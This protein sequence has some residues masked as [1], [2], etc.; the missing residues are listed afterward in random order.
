MKTG[1][2]EA[3]WSTQST[4]YN[5]NGTIYYQ[6]SSNGKARLRSLASCYSYTRTSPKQ[7]NPHGFVS[8]KSRM[9]SGKLKAQTYAAYYGETY[10]NGPTSQATDPGQASAARQNAEARASADISQAIAGCT[11]FAVSAVELTQTLRMLGSPMRNI[12]NLATSLVGKGRRPD[13][14]AQASWVDRPVNFDRTVGTIEAS[15][16]L[17]LQFNLGVRPLLSD[18]YAIAGDYLGM[19]DFNPG[20][21]KSL[22]VAQAKGYQEVNDRVIEP[23]VSFIASNPSPYAINNRRYQAFCSIK[24]AFGVDPVKMYQMK[25]RYL[26]LSPSSVAWE[27]VPASYIVDY[28]YD[29]GSYLH[30]CQQ[31]AFYNQF[32]IY[33][34]YQS[35]RVTTN[36]FEGIPFGYHPSIT[37]GLYGLSGSGFSKCTR[38]D[39]T[40]PT[41]LIQNKPVLR[42]FDELSKTQWSNVAAL[43]ARPFC[44]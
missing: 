21:S 7:L 39:R 11:N 1:S 27:L 31:M 33:C 37:G 22:I 38:Y 44:R 20:A 9:T 16:A 8:Y 15:S 36:L 32:L 17:T 19:K 25:Q 14:S 13:R 41:S 24:A 42:S 40:Y 10:F 5:S 34:Q 26:N 6:S 28:V 12:A 2:E 18:M 43:L 30:N 23:V 29:I 3:P 4:G 35:L